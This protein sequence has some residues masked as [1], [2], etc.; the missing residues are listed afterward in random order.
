MMKYILQVFTGPWQTP[1]VRA[2]D[3]IGRIDEIASRIRVEQVII[4]W[5]TDPA[6]YRKVG[7]HLHGLGIR[8]LLWLPAF[9]EVSGIAEPDEAVDIFGKPVLPSIHQ[10]GEDFKFGCPSSRR[11]LQIV[12][13]IYEKHFSGCGFDGVFLDKIR[14]QSFVAGVSGVLSCGCARCRGAFLKRGVELED[15]KKLYTA[16]KD[17]F[18]DIAA[19]PMNGEFQLKDAVAQRFFEAKEEIIAEA[20]TEISGYF[21][22]KGMTVG[23]DL[24]AP[25]VSRFVSQNYTLITKNADFIKPMLYRMTQAP[26]GIGYEYA[27]FEQHAP[28]ARG[29]M[30]LTTDKAFLDT[31]LEAIQRVPCEKYPGIEINYRADIA[32]TNPG[33]ITES[34]A[35]IKARG[36]AGAALCWNV[37]LAP[38]AHM[39]A[40]AGM[41]ENAGGGLM[42][43]YRK[44]L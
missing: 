7:D 16:K 17:A 21:K 30:K 13:D 18:F 35:A 20:V 14:G 27:L 44:K 15:V 33:Y 25:V 40:I 28:N 4:G 12:K 3:I 36:I 26:A 32:R 34:L 9:S 8:M 23:L 41:E 42:R 2:E 1:N 29:R 24:F 19:Y 39:E 11:N 38:E 22:D 5:N 6:L 43:I 31:Q 37:M 10:E